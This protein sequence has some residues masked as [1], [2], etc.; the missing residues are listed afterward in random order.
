MTAETA[1]A[2]SERFIIAPEE[3]RRRWIRAGWG[4]LFSTAII[5]VVALDHARDPQPSTRALLWSVILVLTV[6][7]LG[8]LFFLLRY[9]R[10]M[11]HHH[12]EL[13]S[14]RLRFVTADES[15]ELDLGQVAAIRLFRRWGRLQ[16]IQLVLRNSRGIRLEGYRD[17]QRLADLL[18]NALPSGKLLS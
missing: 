4:V 3:K 18:Q 6:A 12:L 11:P 14:G 13:A 17:L 7:N 1:E 8:N 5:A 2:T 16:H 10:R 15:S 9:L